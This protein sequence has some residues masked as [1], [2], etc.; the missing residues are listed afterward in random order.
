MKVYLVC[1]RFERNIWSFDGLQRFTGT[2]FFAT[3]L[4]LATVAALTPSHWTVEIDDE[5]VEPI[6]FETD[7]DLIAMG[8]L[9]VQYGR[10]LQIAAEFRRRGKKVVFG[11]P[12][13]TL[14]PEA[15]EGRA[16]YLVCGEAELNWAQFL[17]DFEQGRAEAHYRAPVDKA[18]LEKSPVPRYDLIRSHKYLTFQV[19]TSRGCPFQCEFCDIIVVDGRVPRVKPIEH[20]LAEVH[21]CVEQGARY[22]SFTDANFIGNIAYAK[23]LLRALAEYSRANSYPVE[24]TCQ[25]TINLA[26]YEDLLQLCQATRMTSI[27]VGVESPRHESLLE[28]KK[29]QNTRRD[30]CKDIARIQAH[31]I[32]VMVGMIVGFDADDRRIFEEQYNFLQKLG[33]PFTTCGT[34]VALPNTPLETRLRRA[35]R[36]LDTDFT[37]VHGHGADDSNFVPLQ[38]TRK[39]LRE[40]YDWLL[41][42]LYRYDS[43]GLRIA[44]M[45]SRFREVRDMPARLD[46]VL[47]LVL[48]KVLR[49]YLL[50]FDWARTRFFIGTMW[51][52]AKTGPFSRAKWVEF[53]KWTA[54][55]PS[56]RT[57]VTQHFGVPEGK[58]P[59]RAPFMDEPVS[60]LSRKVARG[61]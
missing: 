26:Q 35:G 46:C 41:R 28:T 58:N 23:R 31:N 11:G 47:A 24:F 36:L 6:N 37:R 7:A 61:A 45:L 20:V 3:P 49:Y 16:D 57:Y 2:Q 56:L 13:C 12:Y 42:S 9:T 51:R 32:S 17:V 60:A 44:T 19:Q 29:Q 50:T 48:L 15:F 5:N 54:V 22:V 10:A 30:I 38:M 18:N 43:F 14:A 39:D 21:H 53:V 34:L 33:T 25:S 55:Y 1:P 59:A 40:G 4:G 52:I 27:F 8:P